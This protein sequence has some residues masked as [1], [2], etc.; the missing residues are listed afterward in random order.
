MKRNALTGDMLVAELAALIDKYSGRDGRWVM[1]LH[2][3]DLKAARFRGFLADK[4]VGPVQ[5]IHDHGKPE[6]HPDEWVGIY[7]KE[8]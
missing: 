1:N 5:N 7:R 8:L 2:Q 6:L 3:N 4:E